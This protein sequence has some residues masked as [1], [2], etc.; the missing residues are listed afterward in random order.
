MEF[1]SDL[2][3]LSCFTFTNKEKTK[4]FFKVQVLASWKDHQGL[5]NKLIEIFVEPDVYS[6]VSAM[7]IGSKIPVI[8]TLN[9]AKDEVTYSIK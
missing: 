6:Q 3:L 8:H 4:Q 9:Y 1:V 2:T 5:K 7:E